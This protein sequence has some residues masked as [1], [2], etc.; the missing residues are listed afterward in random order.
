MHIMPS[1]IVLRHVGFVSCDWQLCG[2]DIFDYI[3]DSLLVLSCWDL[4]VNGIFV[5]LRELFRGHFQRI[6]WIECMQCVSCWFIL[7]LRGA[8]CS[9]W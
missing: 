3:G 9:D 2:W 6:G 1:W 7:R 4:F 8:V 5:K